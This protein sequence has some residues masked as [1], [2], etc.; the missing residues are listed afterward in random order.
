[1]ASFGAQPRMGALPEATS[2]A[3]L[4]AYVYGLFF[5][6]GGITSLNDIIAPKLKEL[7]ALNYTQTMLIQTAFFTAYFLVSLPAAAIVRHIGYLRGAALGLLVMASGCLLF[8]P[9]SQSAAFPLF[10]GAVFVLGAGITLV[11]VV[12]NPLIALLGDPA[13]ASSR[14]TFG[15]AFNSIGTTIFPWVGATV[16]LGSLATVDVHLLSGAALDTYRSTETQVVVR[17]YL[18]LAAA[19]ILVAAVM[20]HKRYALASTPRGE[21]ASVFSALQLL[22]QVRVAWGA[23]SIFCYVG[24]EVAIGT[25]IVSY[26]RQP[27]V[28]GLADKAAGQHVIYY[29]GGAMVGRLIGAQVLKRIKPGFALAGCTAA[30]MTLLAISATTTGAT[31]GWS[32]LAIG[33]FNSIMFPTIFALASAEAGDRHQETSGVICVAIVGGALVPPA[34]GYVADLTGHLQTGLAVPV[35]CY[36][37]IMGFGIWSVRGTKRRR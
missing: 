10:L 6:F 24:A 17:A 14:L 12:C 16:L 37:V 33:L 32:L 29:W 18:V 31:A 13:A 34:L 11:Q 28:M 25:I 9:A 1:M 8:I 7:F 2:A 3:G 15:H 35:L 5:I 21:R 20:W 27:S 30:T 26:L 36:A 22:R 4:S 23:G 19:C